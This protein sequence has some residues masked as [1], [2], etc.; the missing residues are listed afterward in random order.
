MPSIFYEHPTLISFA[1]FF[2]DKYKDILI[3]HYGSNAITT[4]VEE[5]IIDDEIPLPIQPTKT[6]GRFKTHISNEQPRETLQNLNQPVAIVGISG[7]MPES[8]DLDEFWNNIQQG[9]DLISEIPKD[10]W[11]WEE[12]YGDPM[13]EPNKT[14]VKWGGFMKEVDKF[15]SLFFG[16]SP[17]EAELMD[18]QQRIL[19]ETVWKVIEDAGY[20][21]KDVAGTK[22]GVFVGVGT[23]DYNDVIKDAG[24]NIEAQTSTGMA[25]S[26]HVNRISYLLNL[27]G[28]SEPINTACSSSL[29]A[30]HRAVEEIQLGNCEMAIAGGVNVIAS[31]RLYIAFNKAGMLSE[32]GRCKT[33]DKD[34][35][36]YVRGEGVG[37]ILLKP[38]D[39]AI[40]DNDH[41][42]G[43]IKGSHVNHGGHVNSL[44]TPNPNSQ[45]EVISK[46]WEKS[47]I[48][49]ETISY[50]EAHGTGTSLGDPI[51]INGLKKAFDKLY[52]KWGKEIPKKA[53]CGI[54][55]VKTNIGHL[56]TAAGIAG[57]LKVVLAMK[58][59][60]IPASI[61]IKEVNPYIQI[62]D[63]PFYIVDSTKDWDTNG[64]PKRAGISSFGF[65][66]ANAHI[67]IEEYKKPKTNNSINND[68]EVIILSAKNEENLKEY[69]SSLLDYININTS[70]LNISEI[71]YTLSVG[72]EEM[73]D[74]LAIVVGDID[75]LK[76]KLNKF[77]LGE[78]NV[79]NLYAGSISNSN[80]STLINGDEGEEFI[81]LLLN[82]SKIDKIAQL[83]VNGLNI[84]WKSLYENKTYEKISLPT[85]P[86]SKIRCWVEKEINKDVV[87]V[88]KSRLH[89]FIDSN[90]STIEEMCYKKT[91]TNNNPYV[92][93]CIVN[94][95][96]TLPKMTLIEMARAAG[97]MANKNKVISLRNIR[98]EDNI[99]VL[100]DEYRDI[101]INLYCDGDIVEYEV[102]SGI[103]TDYNYIYSQGE[104]ISHDNYAYEQ[105]TYNINKIKESYNLIQTK[106]EVYT[107]FNKCGK[108]YKNTYKVID[109]LYSDG[110]EVLAKIVLPNYI[111]ENTLLLPSLLEAIFQCGI[112]SPIFNN[113]ITGNEIEPI[114]LDEIKIYGRAYKEC[115]ITTS[116][117]DEN[118]VDIIVLDAKGN[119]LIE[120][121]G[122]TISD[123]KFKSP[124]KKIDNKETY[125]YSKDIEK[126]ELL[127][128]GVN[129]KEAKNEI[130]DMTLTGNI[131]V[132]NDLKI[133]EENLVEHIN[134][135]CNVIFV[136]KGKKYKQVNDY[137]YEIDP[138][139]IEDYIT[140]FKD[141]KEKE[142]APEKIA[143]LWSIQENEFNLRKDLKVEKSEQFLS[144][145][146]EP[147]FNILKGMSKSKISSVKRIITL[148][149]S[150]DN[151]S[152]SYIS[153]IMGYSRSINQ[154]WPNIKFSTVGIENIKNN[155]EIVK[156][157]LQEL[158]IK[159]EIKHETKYI[160]NIRYIREVK[161]IEK[162]E[163]C[164]TKFRKNGV[165][166][167]TGGM[168][169]LGFITAKH[170][171]KE[172]GAKL[173]LIGRSQ[174]DES[175][176]NKLEEIKALG[177]EAIYISSDV[178][179]TKD[180]K[181]VIAKGKEKYR[182]LNGVIHTAGILSTKPIINKEYDECREIIKP[183]V[184]G[185][186]ALD[187]AT[188]DE[189]LDLFIMFSSTSA[190]IGDFGQCDYAIGNTFI[191]QYCIAREEM[192]RNGLR[193]G[194]T[195]SIN[196]PM[197]KD[198]GMH[199]NEEGEELYLKSSGMG[200]LRTDDG[201]RAIEEI[202]GSDERQVVVM[203]GVRDRIEKVLG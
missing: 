43:V 116:L 197:W 123:T 134:N 175:K 65:G 144:M 113:M 22:T 6:R 8:E 155:S 60:K 185:S 138:N 151:I 86:F 154:L 79:E 5:V 36:G 114:S 20:K 56:E 135:S 158:S 174:L 95:S 115:Y 193:T 157:I 152:N 159:E 110:K 195:I 96:K 19:L 94:G 170:L 163:Q 78:S 181:D 112:W 7:A 92:E 35:D 192:R 80:A 62:E 156:A 46:A 74:R 45:A 42:Y 49:P 111:E 177:G 172:Y 41:I 182:Q 52:K 171:A 73:S 105:Q 186:V 150:K 82:N 23:D 203:V 12:I 119:L 173:I 128:Y 176:R 61:N 81:K 126:A 37:A 161:E 168:G 90:E 99:D 127:Y 120:L 145:G 63:S 66:G 44:T 187:E 178:N 48:D 84:N 51:E 180:L 97:E 75:E 29:V 54:G 160:N 166:L 14:K 108:E 179:S 3:S 102:N 169:A 31:P 53:Y 32:D 70:E 109:K 133:K 30:V 143:Y 13:V 136:N 24:I 201:L 117:R 27:H 76:D 101:Y 200:Y 33:F 191:D 142:I 190:I 89:L 153:S 50:I 93:D 59:D 77:I 199:L 40:K 147:I 57:I 122:L 1:N 121:K 146:V 137:T 124:I 9:K 183:K 21:A 164:E 106:E 125:L 140:L 16:I 91:L 25:H 118:K 83:W 107:L 10:R 202:V 47:G 194:S 15:D 198:G 26:V 72:R 11:D 148:Y 132:F 55:S 85:Y 129:W 2:L 38:L 18:P 64:V 130:I 58:N 104:I 196:W 4:K 162:L 167:I 39:K 188:K 131:V 71:A 28:P 68:T 17:R 184:Y 98:W 87:N 141:L 165:Y 100:D 103:D 189:Q 149:K 69:A 139:N 34:A 88:N 67:V